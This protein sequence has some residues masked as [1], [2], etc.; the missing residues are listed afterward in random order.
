M[1]M[2]DDDDD[3][4]DDARRGKKAGKK[5][6]KKA[7]SVERKSE[8][9]AFTVNSEYARRFQYNKEREELQRLTEKHGDVAVGKNGKGDGKDSE[10]DSE[11]NEVE[12]E[13]G[14]LPGMQDTEFFEALA[15]VRRRDPSLLNADVR[16]FSQPTDEDLVALEDERRRLAQEGAPPPK[17]LKDVLAEQLLRSH[18]EQEDDSEEEEEDERR[19]REEERRGL[20]ARSRSALVYNEEQRDLKKEFRAAVENDEAKDARRRIDASNGD[21]D[22]DNGGST[23]GESD[24]DDEGGGIFS[25][26]S[27]GKVDAEDVGMSAGRNKAAGVERALERCFGKEEKQTEAERFLKNYLVSQGWR[28]EDDDAREGAESDDD[29]NEEEDEFD[30]DEVEQAENFEHAYNFRYE[31]PGGMELATFS[32]KQ[33]MEQ[34]VRKEKKREAR[35][36]ARDTKKQRLLDRK[37]ETDEEVKRLK[38]LK[39]KELQRKVDRI[40]EVAGANDD[41]VDVDAAMLEEEWDPDAHD[42]RMAELFSDEYYNAEDPES[43]KLI[44]RAHIEEIE[45]INEDDDEDGGGGGEDGANGN[46]AENGNR[47]SLKTFKQAQHKALRKQRRR[48]LDNSLLHAATDH[49]GDGS[50]SPAAAPLRLD[51]S[52]DLPSEPPSH[53]KASARKAYEKALGEYFKLDYEGIAGGQP[54][55]FKYANVKA[56]MY[57]LEPWQILLMDDK[58]L[59]QRV[60]LKQL[61][62]F[63]DGDDDGDVDAEGTWD[64]VSRTKRKRRA[65]LGRD[66]IDVDELRKELGEKEGRM[67]T[68][69]DASGSK[70]KK[71]KKK[72][73][74]M[75]TRED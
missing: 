34:T 45:R 57:G 60:S 21:H 15:R 14:V 22:D 17:K 20:V 69:E 75:A 61:A 18:D 12:D 46:A 74:K 3:V 10:D 70:R 63:R 36:R 73:K 43:G 4:D 47:S 38:N 72:K 54:T 67:K 24:D 55:R 35:K 27:R 19:K 11:D 62:P 52:G 8:Q 58:E 37:R 33:A 25:V 53:L 71:L 13:D 65:E 59:N 50:T 44:E 1:S 16:L 9:D 51:A 48:G 56:N 66:H 2:F 30:H 64:G 29:H 68:F 7:K 39:L 41:E 40:N 32:R 6:S 5:G 23:G 28:D 26:K 42:R 31:E 49:D